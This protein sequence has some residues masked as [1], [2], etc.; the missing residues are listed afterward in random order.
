MDTDESEA[1]NQLSMKSLLQ[2]RVTFAFL[3]SFTPE[4]SQYDETLHLRNKLHLFLEDLIEKFE[5]I[6]PAH[7]K[8]DYTSPYFYL[9]CELIVQ[10]K[11]C[12][13]F[14]FMLIVQGWIAP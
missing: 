8:R 1:P 12:L 5:F 2:K 13:V 4:S 10:V 7:F 6:V 3:L 11:M 14:A 9:R